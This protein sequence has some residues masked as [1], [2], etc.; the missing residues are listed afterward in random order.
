MICIS[1]LMA[2]ASVLNTDTSLVPDLK[3]GRVLRDVIWRILFR[4]DVADDPLRILLGKMDTNKAFRQVSVDTS[5]AP[6]LG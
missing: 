2:V 6:V 4:Y 3:I 1:R 5:K